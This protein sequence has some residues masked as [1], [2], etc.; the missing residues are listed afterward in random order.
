MVGGRSKVLHCLN[1]AFFPYFC[2]M[3]LVLSAT[4]KCAAVYLL[5]QNEMNCQ[6][7]YQFVVVSACAADT[8]KCLKCRFKMAEIIINC[9]KLLS[10]KMI[11]SAYAA[12]C[13]NC[14]KICCHH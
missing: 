12:E 11:L 9:C 8:Y 4:N 13:R 7:A 5:A 2:L 6:C 3:L 14:N 1:F 10:I